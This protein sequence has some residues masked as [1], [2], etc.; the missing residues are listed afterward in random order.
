MPVFEAFSHYYNQGATRIDRQYHWGEISI[1]KSEYIP[2]AFSDH[3]GLFTEVTVPFSISRQCR[4]GG[5]NSFKI[6]NNVACDQTFKQSLAA[7][8]VKWS[9][10]RDYVLIC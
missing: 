8:I 7:E 9:E 1:K 4:K 10:I 2:V 3:L 5:K 6:R